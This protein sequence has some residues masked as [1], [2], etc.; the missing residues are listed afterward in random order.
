MR[1]DVD[2]TAV[3][4]SRVMSGDIPGPDVDERVAFFLT[5]TEP[6]WACRACIARTLDMA[7]R[8][9][10]IALL[11]L[12]RFRGRRYIDSACDVCEGCGAVTAVVRLGKRSHLRRI[13]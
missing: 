9:V 11:R 8:D 1:A 4:R 12:S 13:A 3:A 6:Y 7:L 2:G 5:V 10:K